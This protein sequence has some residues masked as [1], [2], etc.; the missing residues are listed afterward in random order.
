MSELGREGI[1]GR[2]TNLGKGKEVE[3]FKKFNETHLSSASIS[4][5]IGEKH[6][7]VT[8]GPM[9]LKQ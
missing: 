5:F 8:S 7:T 2:W 4:N 9:T 6:I 3:N 1:P